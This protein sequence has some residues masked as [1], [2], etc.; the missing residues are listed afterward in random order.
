M[1][2]RQTTRQTL[3]D[4]KTWTVEQLELLSTRHTFSVSQNQTAGFYFGLPALP[5]TSLTEEEQV[6][7]T[8]SET[9][10]QDLGGTETEPRIK[11]RV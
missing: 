3:K 5:Q 8:Q 10:E 6:S 1:R 9:G 2:S 11:K 7:I 4:V